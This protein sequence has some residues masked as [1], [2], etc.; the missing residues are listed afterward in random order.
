MVSRWSL[1]LLDEAISPSNH[2]E[3][4]KFYEFKVFLTHGKVEN[5]IFRADSIKEVYQNVKLWTTSNQPQEKVIRGSY[6]TR[7][8]TCS[9]HGVTKSEVMINYNVKSEKG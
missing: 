3:L 6:N 5:L 4:R 8:L 9:R 2:S 1:I 7:E